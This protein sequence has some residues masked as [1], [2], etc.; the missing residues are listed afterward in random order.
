MLQRMAQINDNMVIGN[1]GLRDGQINYNSSFWLRTA[2]KQVLI[3]H[4]LFT[5]QM[6]LALRKELL[7]YIQE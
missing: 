1:V 3:A 4:L 6:R 7:P 2:D 5:H